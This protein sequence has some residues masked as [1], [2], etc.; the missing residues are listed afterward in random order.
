MRS[1]FLNKFRKRIYLI[2]KKI[3]KFIVYAR[4]GLVLSSL[5]LFLSFAAHEIWIGLDPN[6]LVVDSEIQPDGDRVPVLRRVPTPKVLV[7]LTPTATPVGTVISGHA[8]PVSSSPT[9]VLSVGED[10]I[11]NRQTLEGK[12]DLA[13]KAVLAEDF[14]RARAYLGRYAE[15]D[16][17]RAMTFYL[18][19]YV[20]RRMDPFDPASIA[21]FEKFLAM[22]A[23]GS[24]RYR[25]SAASELVYLY[26]RQLEHG[27]QKATV[28]LK[29]ILFGEREKAYSIDKE[30]GDRVKA[31]WINALRCRGGAYGK[32]AGNLSQL[33]QEAYCSDKAL[34]GQVEP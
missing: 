26:A 25:F 21:N 16:P 2:G 6:T 34:E 29:G 24:S 31:A 9:V 17:N 8:R 33:G 15:L 13:A 10:D 22:E 14:G 7:A 23:S 28:D 4:V 11:F 12:F 3:W 1:H 19:G 32:W 5:F 30:T 20:E 27:C 18:L